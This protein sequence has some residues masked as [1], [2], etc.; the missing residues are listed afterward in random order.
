MT[1]TDPSQTPAA[2]R[3]LAEASNA[4]PFQEA[5]ALVKRYKDGPPSKGYVLFETGYGPSGLPHMGTF[6][7]VVRTSMVRH[8]FSLLSDIPTKL[9]CFSDDM[10]GLRKVPTNI[11]NQDAMA[12]HLGKPL[13]MVPDPF[14]SH[15]SF[16]AHNN[17]RLCA[18][19]D[20]FGF[21]YEFRSATDCYRSGAMDATLL[22]ILRNY[23]KVINVVLPTLGEERRKTYCPFLPLSPK[24]GAVLQVPLEDMDA[25]AGTVTFRDEDGALFTVPVTGGHV[26]CQWKV[27]W[28]MRWD[29]LDVDYEMAGKDLIESVKLSSAIRRILGSRPPEGFNYELFLDEKG[30]KISKSKGNGLT[31]EEWLAYASPESLSL[32]MFQ[33]PRKAK[34]LYFDVIPKTVDEYYSFVEKFH[35]EDAEAQLKNPAWHV[36]LGDVPQFNLPVSFS[37]LLNLVSA[38]HAHDKAALW[39]FVSRYAPGASAQSHP[40]LDRLMGYALRYYKDFVA[41]TKSFRAPTDMERAALCD[42]LERLGRL[43]LDADA[44]TIQTEV[45][46][47]GKSQPFDTLRDWFKA[48]YE[49]LLGQSQG[50]R[51][52]GFVALYGLENTKTLIA[53]VLA[54]KSP[55]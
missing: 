16:A 48:L 18:F 45:Y 19:L 9:I 32:Y 27:D 38:S 15:E 50:P 55:S 17:A 34:K 42:L 40:E 1:D 28:A 41:P 5:R 23:E 12:A 3:A 51:F 52:G 20:Q 26:K 33:A 44:Q 43:P 47:S 31:I 4:W 24:T 30:E 7:E 49:T 13:S 21:D 8:A 25:D 36:H 11:P 37:L 22:K 39:G 54:G 2:L 53:D 14:G 35:G 29:A 10:D 6:G 46:E